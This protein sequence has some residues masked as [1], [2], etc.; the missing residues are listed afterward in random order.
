M[1]GARPLRIVLALAAATASSACGSLDYA[2]LAHHVLATDANGRIVDLRTGEALGPGKPID[3]LISNLLQEAHEG[4]TACAARAGIGARR[5]LLIHIHGGMNAAQDSLGSAQDA[6]QRMEQDPQAPH[7]IFITWPSGA[8]STYSDHLLEIRQGQ[9]WPQAMG[10]ASAPL[11]LVSDVASSVAAAPV[12]LLYQWLLDLRVAS[13]VAFDWNLDRATADEEALWKV[14]RDAGYHVRR[15]GYSRGAWA[16]FGRFV[17]YWLSQPPKI[18]FQILFLNGLGQGAWEVMLHR[19]RS[20]FHGPDEYALSSERRAEPAALR[21]HVEDKKARLH[22]FFDRL[23]RETCAAEPGGK[24]CWDITLVGHSMGAIVINDVLTT[25]PELPI[26]NIVYMAPACSVRDAQKMVVP[27]LRRHQGTRF[28]LLT[29]HPTA[30][31]DEKFSMLPWYDLVPRGSLLEWIDNWYTTPASHADRTLG[32]WLNVIP[33]IH[34]FADVRARVFLKSFTV[35]GE[36]AP[37]RHGDF[38]DFAFWTPAFWWDE[39]TV[40]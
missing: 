26:K 34:V 22:A 2:H 20:M 14:A 8:L 21:A 11:V 25:Y 29:L 38:N 1:S 33:A 30:E 23:A 37:E 31:A 17:S 19:T 18:V 15:G 9:R 39:G 4:A 13:K 16:Q 5:E 35:G 32:K 40:R 6:L 27:Y 3:Q 7:P 12:T 36:P 24:P 28:F 10:W